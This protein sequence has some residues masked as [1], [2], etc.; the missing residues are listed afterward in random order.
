MPPPLPVPCLVVRFSSDPALAWPL[1][2]TK[3]NYIID[4]PWSNATERA[5]AAGLILA[6]VLMN[7]QLGVRPVTL[8]GYSLGARMIFY[9]LRELAQKKAYGIVQNVYLMGAPVSAREAE[10]KQVRATVS[11]RFVN[12]TP[13]C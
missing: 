13:S 11:G 5:R 1:W 3:L 7:R 10:W 8:V 4:N 9:A 2:L 12:G 6:D